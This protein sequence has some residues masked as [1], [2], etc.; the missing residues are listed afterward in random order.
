[1]KIDERQMHVREAG[2]K[3][4][5]ARYESVAKDHEDHPRNIVGLTELWCKVQ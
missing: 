4:G 3:V 2:I 5:R 1:M